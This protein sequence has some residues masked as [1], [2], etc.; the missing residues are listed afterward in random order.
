MRFSAPFRREF[1][2]LVA[3]VALAHLTSAFGDDKS[4]SGRKDEAAPDIAPPTRED[5]ADQRMIFIKSALAQYTIQ[6]GDRK[7]AA[8]ISDPCLRWTN[9]VGGVTDGVL[10]VY[11]FEGGGR[12]AAVGQFFHNGPKH[13]INEFS[14]IASD[15]VR[16]M[17]S[18]RLFWK[19]SEYICK[20]AD[21][22]DSPVP[23][24][25]PPLRLAQMRRIA[26]D[27]SV[28]DHFGWDES[29]ITIHNLRLLPQPVFRY[30]EAEKILD[31]GL[32]VYALGTDPECNLLL[33]AY[34]DDKGARYRYALA[35]MS[36]YQL[37]ARY[38]DTPV[39][40]V[41]RR[42]ILGARCTKYYAL[43]YDPAPGETVPE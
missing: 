15:N 11:T 36:I 41:E 35:P 5:L 22:P 4:S 29:K 6:V 28:I 34:Q 21:L 23:A 20:F 18:E 9:P 1:V 37:E 19:P 16:I 3:V 10:A 8:T 26:A 42:I 40:G 30:A 27:F 13:W 24:A 25:K 32:F 33:E 31:G 12:P 43:K 7:E 2:L 17:R 38:K 39:W 14:I